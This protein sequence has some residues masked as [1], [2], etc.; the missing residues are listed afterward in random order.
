MHAH[1]RAH[2]Q[3]PLQHARRALRCL[4]PTQLRAFYAYRM[5]RETQLEENDIL[6]GLT[7]SLRSQLTLYVYK[8][9]CAARAG[10][11]V[12]VR[13]RTC[14]HMTSALAHLPADAIW[15]AAAVSHTRMHA[16]SLA[17][18][19]RRVCGVRAAHR[20]PMPACLLHSLAG[21]AVGR[22]R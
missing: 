1:A 10:D 8:G 5:E 13:R 18:A 2:A 21:W 20:G 17:G 7:D 16:T 4:P 15:R 9:E 12:S 22:M 6:M 19:A 11:A 14:K 3:L